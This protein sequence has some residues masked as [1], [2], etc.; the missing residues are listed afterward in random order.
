ML[1]RAL[2]FIGL[3]LCGTAGWASTAEDELEA[4]NRCVASMDRSRE[5]AAND[6][7]F[8]ERARN[9]PHVPVPP[10]FGE[11]LKL[12]SKVAKIPPGAKL[13]LVGVQS[14]GTASI[15]SSGT[16]FVSTRLWRGNLSMERDEAA[17]VIA[18]EIAHLE[19]SHIRSRFCEAV[20]ASGDE[21]I[22]LLQADQVV[23]QLVMATGDRQKA[24][25]M[26]QA[27]H[28][29]EMNADLRAT[30]LLKLAGI[31]PDA[32]KRMLL[33]LA[34]SGRL[35]ATWSHPALEARVEYVMAGGMKGHGAPF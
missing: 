33:K 21:A 22:P 1:R 34:G 27:N 24:L 2:L 20:A 7:Q 8:M 10:Q 11:A 4:Y 19:L 5:L 13:E 28:M 35:E 26:M 12:V 29:R 25:K 15:L 18:H 31:P 6:R 14:N 30:E 23:Q 16:I 9:A 17:A 3:F 32:V